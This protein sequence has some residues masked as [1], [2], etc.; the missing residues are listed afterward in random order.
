MPMDVMWC[1]GTNRWKRKVKSRKVLASFP[2]LLYCPCRDFRVFLSDSAERNKMTKLPSKATNKTTWQLGYL[3]LGLIP[4][5][6]IES[7]P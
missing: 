4:K 3:S 5:R 2:P 7:P 1:A 6:P